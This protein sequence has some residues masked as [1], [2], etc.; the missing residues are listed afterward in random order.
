MRVPEN[1]DR[2]GAAVSMFLTGSLNQVAGDRSE[3]YRMAIKERQHLT[4]P[5]GAKDTVENVKRFGD[6]SVENIIRTDE[7]YGHDGLFKGPRGWGYWNHLEHPKPI[8]NPNLWPDVSSTYFF[9]QMA[10]PAGSTMTLRAA[11]PHARYFQFQLYRAERN[12]FVAIGESFAGHEIEPDSGS[13]NPFRVGANRLAEP[14]NFTLRILAVDAPADPKLREKN[15]LYAGEDGGEL[16]GV[17]RIY[18][19]DQGS[20]G[21]GWGLASTPFAGRGL[22]SYETTLVDGT[23]LSAEEV[24]K[25]FA[26]PMEGNTKPPLTPEQWMGAVHAADN[27]P[28]LDPVTAPA[29]KDPKW[30]KF[31]TIRYTVLGTFL[32]PEERAKIPYAGAMEGGGEGPYL[33]TYLSRQFGPVYVMHGKMPIFPNT[34]AGIGDGGLEV[35]PEAQTQY[36]SL[37]SCEAAPSGRVVDGVTD[38]QVPLDGDRNYTI[39]VSRRE[40]RPQNATI[41]NGITWVEWS[42]RGEGLDDPKNRT[43]FGMLLLRIMANNP[44]W[45]QS[46]DKVTKPGTEEAVMGP[47]YPRGYYTTKDEF[48]IGRL[49]APNRR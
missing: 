45:A 41:E 23:K 16:Q 46:P 24:V 29:R 48:E 14:R 15:T 44:K 28:S 3:I 42:L 26:R 39:V 34:Y 17:I 19:S 7:R 32:T 12:T 9:S 47:Y 40:D 8:Q 36:W 33:V 37:V 1:S 43:D 11:Y 13:S 27:D 38:M 6:K 18:L 49:S 4:T 22:P 21:A 2:D 30:E 10:M 31:W 25:R 35:M 20:D 5:L